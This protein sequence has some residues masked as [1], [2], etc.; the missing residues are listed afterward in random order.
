MIAILD[1]RHAKFN[2]LGLGS[3]QTSDIHNVPLVE[4]LG[5]V[6]GSEGAPVTTLL[7][8]MALTTVAELRLSLLVVPT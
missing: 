3:W 6:L 5:S 2:Y 7:Q 1:I 4:L 8:M